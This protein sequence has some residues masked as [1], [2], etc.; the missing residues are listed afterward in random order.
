VA[1]HAPEVPVV[2]GGLETLLIL[3][4]PFVCWRFQTQRHGRILG[5]LW[6]LIVARIVYC[7][8]RGSAEPFLD[9]MSSN[10]QAWQPLL[11]GMALGAGLVGY[12]VWQRDLAP[13]GSKRPRR[14]FSV[15]TAVRPVGPSANGGFD[16]APLEQGQAAAAVATFL[17]EPGG[18]F[19]DSVKAEVVYS[20]A[21]GKEVFRST[22]GPWIGEPINRVGFKAAGD[23][24][25]LIIALQA[26]HGE[27]LLPDDRR[28]DV[29]QHSDVYGHPVEADEFIARVRLLDLG[30]GTP[31]GEWTFRVTRRGSFAINEI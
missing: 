17:I 27:T 26:L 29:A 30:A 18:R 4:L 14:R 22:A 10:P 9:L 11:F 21:D 15:T 5:G 19:V 1:D 8:A 12:F 20:L 13:A 25:D 24:R 7:A 23:T 6:L 31:I 2:L 3:A 16:R 28:D